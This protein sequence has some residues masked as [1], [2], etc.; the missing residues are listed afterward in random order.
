MAVG[1]SGFLGMY[2][3]VSTE[4]TELRG[5]NL[6]ERLS[7]TTLA[8]VDVPLSLALLVLS[9]TA[10]TVKYSIPTKTMKTSTRPPRSESS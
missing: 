4:G 3:Q 7:S 10:Q 1:W 6:Q 2:Q 5:R 8:W 9:M